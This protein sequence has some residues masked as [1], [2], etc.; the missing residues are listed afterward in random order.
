M[1][2]FFQTLT[3]S[4][5]TVNDLYLTRVTLVCANKRRDDTREDT[6]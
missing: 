6:A 3:Q 5:V 4:F 2:F 1:G